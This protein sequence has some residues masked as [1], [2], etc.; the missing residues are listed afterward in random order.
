MGACEFLMFLFVLVASAIASP[1]GRASA[2]TLSLLPCCKF[3]FQSS[4]Q[5]KKD[6]FLLPAFKIFHDAYVTAAN[7]ESLPPA[8][9]MAASHCHS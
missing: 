7:L 3:N 5:I 2:T 6:M 8:P 1:L 4:Q 9:S